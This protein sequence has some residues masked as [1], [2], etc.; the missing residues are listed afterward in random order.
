MFDSPNNFYFWCVTG[1][2]VLVGVDT[3]LRLWTERHRFPKDDLSE[4][5]RAM[6]WRIV[7][8]LIF[9]LITL[10]ELNATEVGTR[11]FGGELSSWSYGML[12]YEAYPSA[13][14]KSALIPALFSGEFF[15][16]CLALSML[17]ALFF[18]PHPFL[19]TLIGYTVSFVF[20][21]NLI[22]EPVIA[23]TGMSGSKWYL[24]LNEGAPE[25]I[26]PLAMLHLVLAVIYL[27]VIRNKSVRLWFSE[28]TR[29][30]A[31]DRLKAAIFEYRATGDSARTLSKLGILYERAG[32][33]R[34]AREQLK[35]LEKH[36][37]TSLYTY[38]LKALVN[39]GQRKFDKA[40]AAFLYASD[41]A[42]DVAIT[43]NGLGASAETDKFRAQL[44]AAAA[45][46]SFA[47][48]EI[49]QAI[50]LSERAL[51]LD[52]SYL[53]AR[54]VKVDALLRTGKKDQAAQEILI[55]V[56]SGLTLD[57]ENKV[58]LDVETSFELL[59]EMES[60]RSASEAGKRTVLE[61]A[62]KN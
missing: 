51:E 9:P 2:S 19:A 46:S 18:R 25:Q 50:N 10:M 31:S 61:T 32:L 56:H 11:S 28:L 60:Q 22:I 21:V 34:Q 29:P 17:P 62:G 8:F 35:V 40:K 36:H 3:V 57:L 30:D 33:H 45:C 43:G 42:H 5:D 59:E 1:I 44:L 23:L 53:V 39:Y 48:G 26:M 15:I 14:A 16:L 49:I 7:V 52:E 6:I 4:E 27:M 13:L 54:M 41:M 20:A 12:W 55:A 24:A 58:P 47:A 38:F 37:P